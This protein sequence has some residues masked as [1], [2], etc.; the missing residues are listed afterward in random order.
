MATNIRGLTINLSEF[1]D[2]VV[3]YLGMQV[4]NLRGLTTLISFGPKI[5]AAVRRSRRTCCSMRAFSI[6]PFPCTPECDSTGGI[7]NPSKPGHG[8]CRIRSG[9]LISGRI[10][11]AQGFGTKPISCGEDGGHQ[12]RSRQVARVCQLRARG[13]QKER[14]FALASAWGCRENRPF[15]LRSRMTPRKV[16]QHHS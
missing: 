13:R 2:L 15:L 10:L 14:R 11:V 7:F 4:R 16:F 6:H 5:K 8:R 1:P 9:G 3:I 12:R